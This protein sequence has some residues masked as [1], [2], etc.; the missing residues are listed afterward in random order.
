M[1][2]PHPIDPQ[3]CKIILSRKSAR[4]GITVPKAVYPMLGAGTGQAFVSLDNLLAYP[5][6]HIPEAK[7]NHL[8]GIQCSEEE[9]RILQQVPLHLQPPLVDVKETIHCLMTTPD[10]E[11]YLAIQKPNDDSPDVH[12]FLF[13]HGMHVC[14]RTGGL[15]LDVSFCILT[16]DMLPTVPQFFKNVSSNPRMVH[17]GPGAFDML[18]E[19]LRF[20]A[21][22]SQAR[23]SHPIIT[24][25]LKKCF[26]R[27]IVTPL[28]RPS[29]M[30]LN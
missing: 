15:I 2:F 7:L 13:K 10:K 26:V 27:A 3:N 6:H 14:G 30:L 29:Y 12:G 5:R 24:K 28:Y 25:N 4:F 17:M 22:A 1:T 21:Q 19:I 11:Y 9:K 16:M 18:K 23:P 20:W 8:S